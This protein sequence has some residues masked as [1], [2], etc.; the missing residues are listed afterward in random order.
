MCQRPGPG[1]TLISNVELAF[2]AS[3]PYSAR[4]RLQSFDGVQHR[5]NVAVRSPRHA[6]GLQICKP[7]PV[8]C[9]LVLSDVKSDEIASLQSPRKRAKVFTRIQI[10]V[11]VEVLGLL[12][13]ES[14]FA[15]Y[16]TGF[17][18]SVQTSLAPIAPA[19]ANASINKPSLIIR[20][21]SLM[22]VTFYTQG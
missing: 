18:H 11:G 16:L 8:L 4:A 12:C 13:H 2:Q 5:T 21:R 9:R 6:I 19:D 3:I 7:L 20:G 1:A 14:L 10:K 17:P 22:M 15:A